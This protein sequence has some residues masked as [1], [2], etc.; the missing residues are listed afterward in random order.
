MSPTEVD[1]IGALASPIQPI[2]AGFSG[3]GVRLS[4][5]NITDAASPETFTIEE[6]LR[7]LAAA[8]GGLSGG[9]LPAFLGLALTRLVGL[10]LR[11]LL[12]TRDGN[13]PAGA[14]RRSPCPGSSPA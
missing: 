7:V 8:V 2:Y 11:D 10:L 5:T 3:V 9:A 6:L 1:G 13:C 4:E 14:L 12:L